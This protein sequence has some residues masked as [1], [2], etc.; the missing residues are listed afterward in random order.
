MT[1]EIQELLRIRKMLI[2]KS[3]LSCTN[4]CCRVP[5]EEKTRLE[6]GKPAGDMCVGWQ[7]PK[8]EQKAKRLK[9][10]DVYQLRGEIK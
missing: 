1:A 3:C 6:D 4:G 10:Y 8:I 7:N 9:I 5:I 2:N